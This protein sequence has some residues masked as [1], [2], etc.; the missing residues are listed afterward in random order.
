MHFSQCAHFHE[1]AGFSE[2]ND[3]AT[4]DAASYSAH[5]VDSLEPLPDAPNDYRQA[6]IF[7]LR[8][9]YVVDGF[10]TAAPD[11]RVAVVAVATVLGWPS[12]RGLSVGDIADQLGCS[13]S[14]LTR[15][16]ARFKTLAGLGSAGGV[17]FIRPGAG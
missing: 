11:A 3:P 13:P 17:R 7:H 1:P 8:L 15:S 14:T 4:W 9:M 12:A 5:P 16:I 10:I 2:S 6:A